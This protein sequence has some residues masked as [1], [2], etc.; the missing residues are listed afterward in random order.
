MTS[1]P[2]Q[3][4]KRAL[5][6][7]ICLRAL[8]F[9]YTVMFPGWAEGYLEPIRITTSLSQIGSPVARSAGV[10]VIRIGS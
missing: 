4:H 7:T 10:R 2:F 8:L 1:V 5:F 3:Q 9:L 6:V